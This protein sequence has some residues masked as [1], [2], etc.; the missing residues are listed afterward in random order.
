[1]S[2]DIF[3]QTGD[4][5]SQEH[6]SD[7]RSTDGKL[8]ETSEAIKNAVIEQAESEK[9][10]SCLCRFFCGKS[11]NPTEEESSET[12]NQLLLK[13]SHRNKSA[14]NGKGTLRDSLLTI[15]AY[16]L[17][18]IPRAGRPNGLLIQRL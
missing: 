2:R 9:K 3:L 4:K 18:I 17:T 14:V 7:R 5:E 16:L 13:T 1:M 8:P 15:E 10:R 6:T 11:V 12:Q